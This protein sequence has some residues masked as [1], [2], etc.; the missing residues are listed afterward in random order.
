MVAGSC[1]FIVI[2]GALTGELA[3]KTPETQDLLP[4]KSLVHLIL[5]GIFAAFGISLF[6]RLL[7]LRRESR[8]LS[9]H[10]SERPGF[11]RRVVGTAAYI[12]AIAYTFLPVFWSWRAADLNYRLASQG[13]DEL[14]AGRLLS[15]GIEQI[16]SQVTSSESSLRKASALFE[17]LAGRHP[18]RTQFR[19]DASG[20]HY[21]LGV[22]AINR[23]SVTD[24]RREFEMALQ[25]LD[26]LPVGSRSGANYFRQ[27]KRILHGLVEATAYDDESSDQELQRAVTLGRRAVALDPRD[28]ESWRIVGM[29][30]LRIGSY[31]SA[32]QRFQRAMDFRSG[33]DAAIW[34]ATS[35]AHALKEDRR[36][37]Q[38]WFDKA[39]KWMDTNKSTD[40]G[41]M[42][43]RARAASIL[44]A[45]RPPAEAGGSRPIYRGRKEVRRFVVEGQHQ[46]DAQTAY[47]RGNLLLDQGK[48]DEAIAL[49]QKA[50]QLDPD[51]GDA[52]YELGSALGMR[53]QWQQAIVE[54]QQA[55]RLQPNDQESHYNLGHALLTEQDLDAAIGE[56]RRAILLKS[57]DAY[58]YTDLGIALDRKGKRDEAIAAYRQAIRL[59]PS[60]AAIHTNLGVALVRQGKHEEGIESLREALRLQPTAA[61]IHYNLGNALDR[62]G[63]HEEAINEFRA[64][65]RLQ[66]EHGGAHGG[67]G[68]ALS[69][70]GELVEAVVEFRESLRLQPGNAIE[71]HNLAVALGRLGRHEEEIVE[72]RE[73]VRLRAEY[74]DSHNGL[75]WSL[76]FSTR[77]GRRAN[78]EALVHARKGVELAPKTQRY[79][80]TL[81][82][83][84][85]RVGHWTESLVAS[86]QYMALGNGEEAYVW[87]LVAMV[88]WQR[89]DKDE[90]RQWFDKAVQ[91]MKSHPEA[92]SNE[93]FQG[94]YTE[95]K[96]LLDERP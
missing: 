72:F 6:R 15:L 18:D 40:E 23:G 52:H 86:E 20:C 48:T 55:I 25:Q 83:A 43:Q 7:A 75:A 19:L 33:G 35:M 71:H 62:M 95:A 12:V 45:S 36:Q 37:G 91:W 85:Y 16:G 68:A 70:K 61:A 79:Y 11:F 42:I 90:A 73:A 21:F 26:Q 10:S 46:P 60:N 2:L 29:A 1:S 31:D 78:D 4:R 89:G 66:P 44:D 49:F 93:E 88:H 67:L 92:A 59:E 56:F 53:G 82:L 9:E 58:A 5:P 57:D 65:I 87:F 74:A 76:L 54:F 96:N 24:S 3:G 84:E 64:T 34:F 51:F 22:A 50:I 81:A 8:Y 94:L 77:A 13:K 32:I 14:E 38:Y 28:S 69:D 30:Q 17:M 63:K 47:E 27:E 39:V 41:L 80:N